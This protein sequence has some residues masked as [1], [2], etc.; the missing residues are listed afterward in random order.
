MLLLGLAWPALG[1]LAAPGSAAPDTPAPKAATEQARRAVPLV[2]YRGGQITVGDLEKAIAGRPAHARARLATD[3]GRRELLQALVD[4][5]LLAREAERRGYA[6]NPVVRSQVARA[7]ADTLLSRDYAP[8][9]AAVPAEALRRR[10][11]ALQAERARPELRRGTLLVLATRRQAEAARRALR[12]RD[13]TAFRNE[14][15][16]RSIHPS[17]QTGGV[18]GEFDATGRPWPRR[19]GAASGVPTEVVQA[20]FATPGQS[21]SEVFPFAGGFALFRVELPR[22]AETPSAAALEPEARER[23]AIA[24]QDEAVD[25]LVKGLRAKVTVEA[26]TAPLEVLGE[27]DAQPAGIV[28]GAPAAPLDPSAPFVAVEPDDV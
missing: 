9:P 26:F 3:T 8:V 28:S 14:A 25:G 17:R 18:F 2:R 12:N 5:A 13:S 27:L 15:R 22:R 19:Q 23:M 10:V 11:Q 4:Y 21:V 24:A 1:S 6:E 16:R 20:A 7:S